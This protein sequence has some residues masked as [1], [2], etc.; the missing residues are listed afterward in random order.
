MIGSQVIRCCL[1]STILPSKSVTRTESF[2]KNRDLAVAEKEN[3]TRVLQDRRNVGRDKK[4]A[5]AEADDD[6]RAPS[7]TEMI[8]SGSSTEMI[9]KA[10]MPFKVP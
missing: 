1:G 9:D 8:V 3:V 5:V 4:L 6:R 7:R 2:V 10:K